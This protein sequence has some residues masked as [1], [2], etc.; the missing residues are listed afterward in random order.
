MV[1]LTRK[2][3]AFITDP[4]SFPYRRVY[5]HLL[6]KRLEKVL[7]DLEVVNDFLLEESLARGR[8]RVQIPPGPKLYMAHLQL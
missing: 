5:R 3:R 8:S 2:L 4:E 1:L 7:K 6:R